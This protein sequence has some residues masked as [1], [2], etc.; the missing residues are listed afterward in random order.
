[1]HGGHLALLAGVET[2]RTDVR[3]AP[4]DEDAFALAE[5]AAEGR[6]ELRACVEELRCSREQGGDDHGS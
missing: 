5:R 3:S 6:A 4:P 1:M 2:D